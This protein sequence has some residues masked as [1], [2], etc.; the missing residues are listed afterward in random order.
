MNWFTASPGGTPSIGIER[1]L[2][3]VCI[4]AFRLSRI[5]SELAG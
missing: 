2:L 5:L 3:I 1:L 4:P